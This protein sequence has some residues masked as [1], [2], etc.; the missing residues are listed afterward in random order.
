MSNGGV[1]NRRADDGAD[2][3]STPPT[4]IP[5]GELVPRCGEDVQAVV[6]RLLYE[7]GLVCWCVVAFDEAG[8]LVR[9]YH[10]DNDMHAKA[11]DKAYEEWGES[12]EVEFEEGDEWKADE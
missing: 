1:G 4:S 7:H 11:L 9:C 5:R 10:A 2:G 3:G 12:L 8:N 6:A